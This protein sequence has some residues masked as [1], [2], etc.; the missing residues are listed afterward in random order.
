MRLENKKVSFNHIQREGTEE[1]VSIDERS[2]L[3]EKEPSMDPIV[4]HIVENRDP[5]TLNIKRVKTYADDTKSQPGVD[6]A[7]HMQKMKA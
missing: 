7:G 5:R 3:Y 2:S 1:S 6:V 4:P